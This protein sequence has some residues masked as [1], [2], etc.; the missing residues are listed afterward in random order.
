MFLSKIAGADFYRLGAFFGIVCSCLLLLVCMYNFCG[1]WFMFCV[2]VSHF[3]DF[4]AKWVRTWCGGKFPGHPCPQIMHAYAPPCPSYLVLSLLYISTPI[5][6]HTHPYTPT[7]PLYML[8]K[9][10]HMWSLYFGVFNFI[11]CTLS[12]VLIYMYNNELLIQIY[13]RGTDMDL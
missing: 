11:Y 6:I 2:I 3:A 13:F 5:R 1:A 7:C 4:L 12:T 8:I 9:I 10:H